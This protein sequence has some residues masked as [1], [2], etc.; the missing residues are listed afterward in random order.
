MGLTA[1]IVLF[2]VEKGVEKVSKVMMPV[3]VVLSIGIA[4]YS[5]CLPNALDGV[6]YYFIDNQYYLPTSAP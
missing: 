3:L 5:A 6:I 4:V 2:G 1:L